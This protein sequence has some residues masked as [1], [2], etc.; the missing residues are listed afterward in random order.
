MTI[1]T[2]LWKKTSHQV[3][4]PSSFL[5][6]E[7]KFFG[8]LLKTF[9]RICQSVLIPPVQ[10]NNF[11]KKLPK[12]MY[13]FYPFWKL[14]K[15]IRPAAE[16][17]SAV[18][19]IAFYMCRGTCRGKNFCFQENKILYFLRTIG[20]H[21]PAFFQDISV[22][23]VKIAFHLSVGTTWGK[24]IRKKNIIFSSFSDNELKKSG[25]SSNSL[26]K[27]RQNSKLSFRG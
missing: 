24:Q 17:F 8:L 19:E 26:S 21:F 23:T 20:E 15:L 7:S 22:T 11:G 10:R 16:T 9:H 18:V 12:I 27:D 25:P 3:L 1:G 14:N 2:L 4:F 6:N 5:D 13:F